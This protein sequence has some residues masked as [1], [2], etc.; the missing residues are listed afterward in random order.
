MAS[1]T[2]KN[3][4]IANFLSASRIIFLPLL[5]IFYAKDMLNAFLISYIII[6]STDFFDGLVARKLNQVTELGKKLDSFADVFFY[7]STAFF[8][9]KIFPEVITPNLTFLWIVLSLFAITLIYSSIMFKKPILMHTQVLRFAAVM[10]GISMLSAFFI[11]TPY[12]ITFTLFC[13]LIG[14]SEELL[15]FIIYGDVDPDTKW[16]TDLKKS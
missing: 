13:Y 15:I 8:L 11:S 3:M 9:Y 14:F 6:G 7:L 5:Y 16:I 4:N 10:V 12:I 1:Q 2:N